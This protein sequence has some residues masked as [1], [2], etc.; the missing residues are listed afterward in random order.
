MTT[1]NF[2]SPT[3]GDDELDYEFSGTRTRYRNDLL[4]IASKINDSN[5]S[6]SNC[7]GSFSYTTNK[8]SQKCYMTLKSYSDCILVVNMLINRDVIDKNEISKLDGFHKMFLLLVDADLESDTVNE[9]FSKW[10]NPF[11]NSRKNL[12]KNKTSTINPITGRKIQ[13]KTKNGKMSKTYLDI[14]KMIKLKS[15]SY[16]K[17]ENYKCIDYDV[18]EYCVISYLQSTLPKKKYQLIKDVLES[19]PTPTYEELTIMLNDNIQYNVNVFILLNGEKIQEQ[20]LYDK[21]LNILIHNEHMYVVKVNKGRMITKINKNILIDP[22]KFQS[23]QSEIYTSSSKII[24]GVK[25]KLDNKHKLVEDKLKLCSSFSNKNIDFF[26]DCMIRAPRYINKEC[27]N[28]CTGLDINGAYYNIL[29]NSDY[30]FPVQNGTEQTRKYNNTVLDYGFYY[31]EDIKKRSNIEICLF[32][33]GAFWCLGYLINKIK[34]FKSRCKIT[35]RH[36]P[37]SHTKGGKIDDKLSKLQVI[38]YTGWLA[39]RS[40]EKSYSIEC[41]GLESEAYLLKGNGAFMQDGHIH[42][43]EWETIDEN[44]KKHKHNKTYSYTDSKEREDVIKKLIKDNIDYETKPNISYSENRFKATSGV[45]AYL[46][47]LCYAKYQLYMIYNEVQKI[48]NF[49]SNVYKIYTDS[50]TFSSDIKDIDITKLNEILLDKY[51]FTVKKEKSKYIWNHKIYNTPPPILDDN[52]LKITSTQ[53][54]IINLINNNDSFS[55]DSRAGYGKTYMIKNV[56]VPYILQSNKTYLITTTTTES[57]K[58]Y[59]NCKT[60]QNI[61]CSN[62]SDDQ[63]LDKIFTNL[64]YLIIDEVSYLSMNHLHLLFNIQKKYNIK[65]ILSGDHNQCTYGQNLMTTNLFLNLTNNNLH[66]IEYHDKCRYSKDY[67]NFLNTLLTFNHG[68]DDICKNHIKTYFKDNIKS[69]END[70]DTN[71][72]KLTYTHRQGELLDNYITTHSAQGMTLDNYSIYESDNMP[73]SVLYTA[74]SRGRDPKMIS[75]YL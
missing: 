1:I 49:N 59:D 8:K 13:L 44:G 57:T 39:K 72:I 66:I 70:I 5:F 45:Y 9:M 30:F 55:I 43:K 3:G 20:I 19:N 67:D 37:S 16:P 46:S 54:D 24:N 64:N 2:Y 71:E 6:Y 75:I 28:N 34:G 53:D 60:I 56:I 69:Y 4:N 47:I 48:K 40:Y 41:E 32:G 63:T 36:I 31:I 15:V 23:M 21:S 73:L 74:L 25:Y 50:I 65:I 26:N 17:L 35:Y 11:I 42:M 68:S 12:I 62:N 33:N 29:C 22:D 51:K 14:F 52:K 61:I 7:K 38:L 27:N 10:I 18:S 58:I